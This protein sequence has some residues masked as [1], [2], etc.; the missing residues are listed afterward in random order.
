MALSEGLFSVFANEVKQSS[1]LNVA[2][3]PLD[4]FAKARNDEF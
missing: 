3:T 1:G 2:P 4:C